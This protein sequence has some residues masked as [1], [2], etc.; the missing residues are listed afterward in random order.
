MLLTRMNR[1]REPAQVLD[2]GFRSMR[3]LH[4]CPEK[5]SEIE[6]I[7]KLINEH[8]FPNQPLQPTLE[9]HIPPASLSPSFVENVLGRLFGAHANGLKAYE[10]F[11]FCLLRSKD[12][13]SA[14]AFEKTVHILTRMRYFDK[15]WD[16]MKEIQRTY[17]TLLTLKSMNIML[18]RIAKHQSYEDTLEAFEKMER[19]IFVGKRFGTEEFNA[20]I[21][22]FCTQRQMKEAKSVF[23]K[24]HSRFSPNTKTM[25]ILLLG[26]KEV[27][28]VT[29]V[30]LFYHEMVRRG[31]KPN[32][33]TYNIRID[34]YCKKGRLDDALRLLR[35][36][37]SVNCVPT[38]ETMTTLIYG[39][40]IARNISKTGELFDE[41][42]KRDLKP[43][44]CAYNALL[45]SLLRSRDVKAAAALMDEMDEKEIGHDHLTYHTMFW[46]F[47]RSEDMHGVQVLYTKMTERG[48]L[49]TT[50]SVVMLMKFFC[51]NHSIDLGLSLWNYLVKQGQCP[52]GHALELLV[53]ALCSHG[54][55]EEALECSKQMVERGRRL[56]ELVFQ[57]LK[58][59]L[60]ELGEEEK[61]HQLEQMAKKVEMFLPPPNVHRKA[62]VPCC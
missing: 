38:L 50:R 36:M 18:S 43:D 27:G 19:E 9:S 62:S 25:N 52:H 2:S 51:K 61:L 44:V 13:P 16:L 12:S 29:A 5:A 8:S 33:V 28:N 1:F 53:T 6:N 22:A 47:I 15:A 45:S 31:F 54:R 39:A 57:M 34:A 24:L 26:F 59:I 10:F 41:M 7:V 40:G 60:L 56:S 48:F 4:S 58:R 14:G 17:P 11:K 49:P 21:R 20:L 30:E 46:G 35:E 23:N 42:T 3:C 55:V 37:E 32:H